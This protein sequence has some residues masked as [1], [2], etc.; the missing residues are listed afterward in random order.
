MKSAA[1]QPPHEVGSSLDT[2][3]KDDKNE[4]DGR[5][6]NLEL[7]LGMSPVNGCK[8]GA[9]RCFDE[10]SGVFVHPWS[11]AARQ[12]NAALEQAH[13]KLKPSLTTVPRNEHPSAVVGWPPVRAFR[14]NL[15]FHNQTGPV[16]APEAKAEDIHVENKES[17]ASESQE[18]QTKFV[19]VNMDGC[20]V[21]RKIDLKLH[22]GYN[23]LSHA[24]LKMF[25]NFFSV[26]CL[27]NPKQED[28]QDGAIPTSYILLYEDNEGDRMLAGDVPWEYVLGTISY[29]CSIPYNSRKST[30]AGCSSVQ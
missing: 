30:A 19:K 5:E 3:V 22:D 17:M 14:R 11:L 16:T 27:N 25:H 20:T 26:N 29:Q 18:G 8:S 15:G 28:E 23:S 4:T 12:Q 10:T 1:I 21:G 2:E 24:L 6:N 13:Q 7:R 9:K